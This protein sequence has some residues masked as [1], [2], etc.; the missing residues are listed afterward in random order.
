MNSR[1]KGKRGELEFAHY[2]TDNGFPAARGQQFA[3]GAES[4]D[5][6]CEA[7]TG[8]HFE[9]KRVENLNLGAACAQAESDAAG[10]PWIVAHRKNDAPW[11]ATIRMET[12][13]DLIRGNLPA[14]ELI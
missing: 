10:K 3:G 14:G 2:L 8:F 5:I 1:N 11:L 6:K 9:V 13:L 7:L 4:P 12:L